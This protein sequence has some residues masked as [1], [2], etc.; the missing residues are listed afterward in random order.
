MHTI[1]KLL[2]KADIRLLNCYVA[3]CNRLGCMVLSLVSA[4]YRAPGD[5]RAH[6]VWLSGLGLSSLKN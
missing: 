6:F 2:N 3:G 1:L 5:V 4:L